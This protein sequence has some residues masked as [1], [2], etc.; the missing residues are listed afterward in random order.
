MTVYERVAALCKERNISFRQMERNCGL[1]NSTSS[2]WKNGYPSGDAL[3]KLSAYF[4]VSSDYLLGMEEIKKENSIISDAAIRMYNR[5]AL[6]E[7]VN[8]LDKLSDDKIQKV[9]DLVKMLK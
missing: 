9:L 8:D 5:P 1:G 3:I 7:L 6:A 2:R 4:G